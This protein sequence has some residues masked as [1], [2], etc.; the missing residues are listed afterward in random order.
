MKHSQD[1]ISKLWSDWSKPKQRTQS[2]EAENEGTSAPKV[3]FDD[4]VAQVISVPSDDGHSQVVYG[5]RPG[6]QWVLIP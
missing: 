5:R 3:V 4:A 1:E 6:G 2:I